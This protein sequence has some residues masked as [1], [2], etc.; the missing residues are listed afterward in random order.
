MAECE[1]RGIPYLF[2]LRQTA[3]VKTLIA[4]LEQKGGWVYC[5]QG[6]EG[7]EGELQLTGWSCKRRVIVGR[8]RIQTEGAKE[9]KN[10][11]PLLSQC[12][13]LPM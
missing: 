6:F 7:I 11:L 2:K 8:R 13:E 5:G 1:A 12:G 9:E 3:K 10:A 4:A